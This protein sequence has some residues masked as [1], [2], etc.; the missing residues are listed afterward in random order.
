MAT[1]FIPGEAIE[2][3]MG[4]SRLPSNP[5][6]AKAVEIRE[7]GAEIFLSMKPPINPKYHPALRILQ[8]WVVLAVGILIAAALVPG[9]RFETGGTLLLVVVLLSLLNAFLKPLLMLFAL[10]F[11]MLTLGLGILLINAVLF[12]IAGRLVPGFD[13]DGFGSAFLGALIISGIT[14][15]VS[16]LLPLE[17]SYRATLRKSRATRRKPKNDDDVIDI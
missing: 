17:M 16:L 9:I 8:S 4:D 2:F 11:I 3:R 13:V 15:F 10:P 14:F 12:L 6:F 1:G 5:G 7:G